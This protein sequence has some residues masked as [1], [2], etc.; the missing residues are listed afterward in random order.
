MFTF[1]PF[2]SS[3]CNET[4]DFQELG[5]NLGRKGFFFFHSNCMTDNMCW[6][7]VF[8]ISLPLLLELGR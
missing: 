4:V 8:I 7:N 3:H 6:V 2:R 5:E 1:L